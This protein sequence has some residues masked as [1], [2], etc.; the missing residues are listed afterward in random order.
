MIVIKNFLPLEDV[1]TVYEYAKSSF[2]HT[3]ENHSPL[4]DNLFS[5]ESVNFHIRTR[6][7]FS[8]EILQIFSKYSKQFYDIVVDMN[9]DL[10]YLPPMF[11]KHYI[12]RYVPE[13]GEPAQTD[14]SRPAHTLVGYVVWNNDYSGGK[15]FS[16][17][18][19][20]QQ[21]TEI[22]YSPGDLII[23]E[24]GNFEDMREIKPVLDGSLYL[25]K[26]WLGLKGQAW[27]ANVDYDKVEWDHW[28]IRG[29]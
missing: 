1:K 6:G 24:E 8:D 16:V 19:K 9:K 3:K 23:F 27:F 18:S 17:N 10:E 4:H 12:A 21:E 5:Q 2:F 22:D 14:I 25:S 26:S 7:E 29:F 20:T 28:E 15:L 11:S 13:F